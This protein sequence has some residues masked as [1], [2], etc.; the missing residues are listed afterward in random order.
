MR[1]V[2]DLLGQ[3][4]GD[5]GDK[6]R[7]RVQNLPRFMR[8]RRSDLAI[9]TYLLKHSHNRSTFNTVRSIGVQCVFGYVKV[10]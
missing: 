1:V 7:E 9:F 10:E 4:R 5:G 3:M 2:M 6:G 8:I